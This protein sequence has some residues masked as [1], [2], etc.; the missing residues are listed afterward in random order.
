MAYD[1]HV[2]Q[3]VR[4]RPHGPGE[5]WAE[6]LWW[7]VGKTI[8]ERWNRPPTVMYSVAKVAD[9]EAAWCLDTCVRADMLELAQWPVGFHLPPGSSPG[10]PGRET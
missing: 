6:K 2:G 5:A 10:T 7:I 4:Y 3:V 9:P 8:S 1:Y